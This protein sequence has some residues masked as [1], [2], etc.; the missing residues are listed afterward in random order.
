M[1]E[2]SIAFAAILMKILNEST[3]AMNITVAGQATFERRMTDDHVLRMVVTNNGGK[4]TFDSGPVVP[5]VDS[6]ELE[7]LIQEQSED[8]D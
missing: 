7:R 2:E 1:N 6:E 3:R 8:T 5:E 4:Y